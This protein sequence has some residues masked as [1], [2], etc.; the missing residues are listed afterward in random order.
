MIEQKDPALATTFSPRVIISVLI[1]LIAVAIL[2]WLTPNQASVP[3][4]IFL[5]G[6]I[7]RPASNNFDVPLYIN[8]PDNYQRL[9][10]V[11]IVRHYSADNSQLAEQQIVDLARQMAAQAGANGIIVEFFAHSPPDTASS[12]AV[13]QFSGIAIYTS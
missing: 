9:G 3:H 2:L 6:K 8:A 4:G 7:S 13:Y 10:L 5:P 1:A 11:R 12:Q